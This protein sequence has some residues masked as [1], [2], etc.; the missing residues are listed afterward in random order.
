MFPP[1]APPP[2]TDCV[3]PACRLYALF[4]CLPAHTSPRTRRLEQ[5]LLQWLAA[6]DIICTSDTPDMSAISS[7]LCSGVLLAE[8]AAALGA[9]AA[10]ALHE[11]PVSA[12]A[13]ATNIRAV[14]DAVQ[15]L[16]GLQCR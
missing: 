16:P 1:P 12:A 10:V 5:Q 13:R 3:F 2:L 6:L 8:V 9:P 14:L 4:V 7:E 15:Q 11:R